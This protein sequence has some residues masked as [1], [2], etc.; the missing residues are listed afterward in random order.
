MTHE[1]RATW[2]RRG[3]LL[4]LAV[5]VASGAWFYPEK[6]PKPA[7]TETEGPKHLIEILHFHQPG[8]AESETLA[9][10][11]SRIEEKYGGQVLVTRID[12]NAHPERAREEKVTKPPKVVMMAGELRACKFQGLWTKAQI[13][14]KVEEI[15]RGLKRMGKDWRPDVQGMKPTTGESAAAPAPPAPPRSAAPGQR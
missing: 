10:H 14:F 12:V 2:I 4:F 9:D 15:L 8:N 11:L 5:I 7:A 3:F 13:E 6:K 1:E